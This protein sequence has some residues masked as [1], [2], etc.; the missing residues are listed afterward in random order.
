MSAIHVNDE[1]FETQVSNADG[2]VLVD[3]WAPWCGPCRSMSP[4]VDEVATEL[5]G[6]AQVF[7]VNVDDSAEAA[8]KFGVQSIPAFLVLRNGEVKDRFSGVVPKQKLLDALQTH[9]N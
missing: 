5:A 8:T 2:A 1:T 3:F 4:V 7:K 9:L 6:N